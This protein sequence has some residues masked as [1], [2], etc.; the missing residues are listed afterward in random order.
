MAPLGHHTRHASL[1]H[2]ILKTSFYTNTGAFLPLNP[3]KNDF[4]KTILLNWEHLWCCNFR[5]K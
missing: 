4:V 2:K 5:G 3:L 1:P